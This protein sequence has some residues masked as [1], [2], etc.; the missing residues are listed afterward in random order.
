MHATDL[1]SKGS[2]LYMHVFYTNTKSNSYS[3]FAV[4][5]DLVGTSSLKVGVA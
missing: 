2:S 1:F 3:Q 5:A 4:D